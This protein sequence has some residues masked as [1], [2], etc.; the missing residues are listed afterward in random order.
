MR[1]FTSDTH[2]GH[3]NIIK[4]C[5]RPFKDI[6]HMDAVI[7]DNWNNVVGPEDE[8]WHLG[9]VAMGPWERWNDILTSLNGVKHLVI[10]NHDRIFAGEKPRMQERFESQYAKWFD[11]RKSVACLT[12]ASGHDVV[13]SHFP[14]DGDSHDG[15]R[16]SEYR[17]IDD[18]TTLIHGHTHLNQI[19]TRSQAGT[20]QIHVGQDAFDFTPVSEDQ[21]IKIIE[22][23]EN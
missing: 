7:A 2:F 1:F 5:N 11:E 22:S 9:D 4:Y 13:L 17:E 3:A 19:I 6:F 15:D 20:L 12:L 21:I 14:Y 23:Q 18:G 16:Y 8:V 10:G